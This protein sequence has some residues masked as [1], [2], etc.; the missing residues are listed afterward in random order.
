[1]PTGDPGIPL[2]LKIARED[3]HLIKI[4][5]NPGNREEEYNL[6]EGFMKI[7]AIMV[8]EEAIKASPPT[9]EVLV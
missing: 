5:A 7:D 3:H 4:K 1:M 6:E 8:S 9:K 2:E